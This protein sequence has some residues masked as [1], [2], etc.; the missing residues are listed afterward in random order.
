LIRQLH[1]VFTNGKKTM[2]GIDFDQLRNEITM[3]QVLDLVGFEPTSRNGSQ[4]YGYC[5]LHDCTS[6][7]RRSFSVNVSMRVYCCHKCQSKGSQI[8]LWATV[9][10]KPLYPATIDL[11]RLLGREVPWIRHW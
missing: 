2:P 3:E 8:Q 10:D 5:P 11:C 7:G 1:Q 4:W 9:T 6:E